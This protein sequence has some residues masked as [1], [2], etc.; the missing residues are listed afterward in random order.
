MLALGRPSIPIHQLLHQIRT[1]T[2]RILHHILSHTQCP[3]QHILRPVTQLGKQAAPD[4]VFGKIRRAGRRHGAGARVPDQ[5][6]QEETRTRLHDEAAARED[7]AD[8]CVL[9][10]DPDVHGQ[11]H[12]DADADGGALQCAD[13]GFAAVEYRQCYAAAAAITQSHTLA[14][15]PTY[16]PSQP[17][18]LDKNIPIPMIHDLLRL[19]PTRPL[20]KPN[21]EIRACAENPPVPRNNNALDAVVDIE[22]GVRLLDLRA[23][24]VRKRIVLAGPVQRQHD[25]T[26]L[27]GVVR[28]PDR[29]ELEVVVGRRQGD[30]AVARG[31]VAAGSHCEVC[32]CDDGGMSRWEGR[33][34]SEGVCP[35]R[36]CRG[37]LELYVI[38]AF[39]GGE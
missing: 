10:R 34:G 8:L 2:T 3:R 38:A 35:E 18:G 39:G 25:D 11:S 14:S 32:F 1:H 12:G 29:G 16:T 24:R 20:P 37:S 22:H 17:E 5:P 15:V 26:R 31:L 19:R 21:L 36:H 6:R 33:E 13:G 9:V 23:H 27:G 30:V 7:K 28:G 4:I